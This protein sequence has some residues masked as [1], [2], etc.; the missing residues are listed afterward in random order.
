MTR[1]IALEEHFLIPELARYASHGTETVDREA[2]AAIAH[3]LTDLGEGRIEIMDQAGIDISVLSHF[4]P[5]VHMEQDVAVAQRTA[6]MVNDVLA[7]KIALHPKR[8]MGFAHLSM[9]DANAAADELTRCVTQLGFKGAMLNGH[10]R[11]IYLDDPMYL[12]FWERVEALDVPIYL[13]PAFPMRI[14]EALSGYPGLDGATFGWLAETAGHAL[15]IIQSGLFDRF[16]GVQIILGHMGEGLPFMFYRLDH[17]SSF[18]IP[19]VKLQKG[20]ISPYIRSNFH[21][22][23]SAFFS[24]E[25]LACTITAMGIDRVMFAVDAPLEDSLR[26]SRFIESVEISQDAREQI[27]FRNA[28]KLLKIGDF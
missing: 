3:R 24:P 9:H 4:S 6:R 12:P 5:G 13:H 1:K 20:A 16:P 25:A 8:L 21:A 23:P 26:G 10:T 27:C 14:P 7:E 18:N 19:R 2:F 17:G 28:T 11:G 22:T 15:R